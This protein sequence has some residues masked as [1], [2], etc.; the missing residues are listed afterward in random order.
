MGRKSRYGATRSVFSER[1]EELMTQE[2][3]IIE[4]FKLK[5]G[6]KKTTRKELAE[7]IGVSRQTIG[8][9][10]TGQNKPEIEKVVEIAKY[11]GV[12][13]DWLLGV[14]GATRSKD[15]TIQAIC[16][17]TVLSESSASLLLRKRIEAEAYDEAQQIVINNL[18]NNPDILKEY[19]LTREDEKDIEDL[20]EQ[21]GEE[22]KKDLAKAINYL[23]DSQFSDSFIELLI[24]ALNRLER[25]KEYHANFDEEG[26]A[27]S[28][29]FTMNGTLG[30]WA[31]LGNKKYTELINRGYKV[32]DIYE[33]AEYEITSATNMLLRHFM[34]EASKEKQRINEETFGK[35][36]LLF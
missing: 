34:N 32:I 27:Y 30:G 4:G 3:E 15:E 5:Q 21:V 23:L 31:I 26:L 2:T 13:T 6:V 35:D 8:Y 11:F 19:T 7:A 9:Y 10:L 33:G 28:S 18:S 24:S 16:G 20:A 17:A 29:E 22:K 12:T 25:M 36:N 14:E 1:L